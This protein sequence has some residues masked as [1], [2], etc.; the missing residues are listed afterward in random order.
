MTYTRQCFNALFK[1]YNYLFHTKN[2]KK[3][4]NFVI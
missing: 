1:K 3:I 2:G 4:V